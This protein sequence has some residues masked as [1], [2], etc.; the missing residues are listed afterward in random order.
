MV[1]VAGGPWGAALDLG[2]GRGP[3]AGQ[4]VRVA[5]AQHTIITV[6]TVSRRM[7]VNDP[8]W[9]WLTESPRYGARRV[10]WCPPVTC[11]TWG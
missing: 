4:L 6:Q 7:Q 3:P 2:Q 11:G 5:V 9:M 10:P 1:L 8:V